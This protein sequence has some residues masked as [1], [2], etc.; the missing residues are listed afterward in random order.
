[1]ARYKAGDWKSAIEALEK[2]EDV[3][4]GSSSIDWLFRS[5]AYAQ[6]G[7]RDEAQKWYDR[8]AQWID[9]NRPDFSN[10]RNFRAAAAEVLKIAHDKSTLEPE[11][12]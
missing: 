8:A 1:M 11:S 4:K 3:R 9:K 10:H 6:L 2:S 5:M 12:K 7:N